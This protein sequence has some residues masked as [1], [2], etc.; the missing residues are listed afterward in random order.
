M[1]RIEFP[2]RSSGWYTLRP[3]LSRVTC[4]SL[5]LS[6][7]S[8]MVISAVV[9]VVVVVVCS[10]ESFSIDMIGVEAEMSTLDHQS[11]QTKAHS[12]AAMSH[13]RQKQRRLIAFGKAND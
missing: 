12:I 2:V 5:V 10:P 8:A 3:E 4:V 11:L 1:T 7:S 9:V 6:G 13:R